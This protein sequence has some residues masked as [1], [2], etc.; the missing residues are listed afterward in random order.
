MR[1]RNISN[2]TNLDNTRG[3]LFFS[4]R[5]EELTFPYT[6]DSYKS[7]TTSL[8]GLAREALSIT[9]DVAGAPNSRQQ[10]AKKSISQIISEIEFR[11]SGNWV[12]KLCVG[13]GFEELSR[14]DPIASSVDHYRRWLEV[15]LSELDG[16]QYIAEIVNQV[17]LRAGS[18]KEKKKLDF[19]A[20]E[21]VSTLQ[22]LGVSR[23]HIHASIIDFFFS[24]TEVS[25]GEAIKEFCKLVFP[26]THKYEV[27]IGVS[28]EI[29]T[30]NRDSLKEMGILRLDDDSE[31]DGLDPDTVK[32]LREELG[33][34]Q[35]AMISVRATD[36]NS[37]VNMAKSKIEQVAAFFMVFNH[38]S[39]FEISEDAVAIQACCG[40]VSKTLKLEGNHMH[41]IRD[42]RMAKASVS[43]KKYH[44][45][46]SLDMGGDHNKFRNVISIHSLSLISSSPDI[47]L[48]NI[49]TCLETI[50]T[51]REGQSNISSVVKAIV[52]AI[53][54]GYINRLVTST[55]FDT[56]NWDRR[57][58]T[59]SLTKADLDG[60][61]DLMSKFVSL[62]TA[63]KNE[64]ALRDLLER[65]KDFE[66]LRFRIYTLAML[67]RDPSK[68][69]SRIETHQKLVTWQ[70][71]RIYRSRNR[72]VH[73]GESPNFTGYLV[74]NAHDFF[75]IALMFCLE[76]SNAKNGYDTFESCF[77]FADGTCRRYLDSLE[78]N[79][80]IDQLWALPRR[81]DRDFIFENEPD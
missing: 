7:P 48:V 6:L 21:F 44:D 29:A 34:R 65:C 8:Q 79:A 76:L 80:P 64:P 70:L 69:K 31:D 12:A 3:L 59:K 61:S 37:A 78:G 17:L 26:H 5:C 16:Q 60:H 50:S 36:Y 68:I 40:G 39:R 1:F 66:L 73:S 67:L 71:H 77:D 43:F 74:E 49:W 72:I 22:G 38:R 30:I 53:T 45:G 62:L 58:F 63:D 2:W 28:D 51:A 57:S 33:A 32:S 9:S 41:F 24:S 81:K 55:V 56:L 10:S 14:L 20:K 52:P 4:Q 25:D 27:A 15:T 47:Q 46:I 13:V 19:L 18:T 42:M 35:V 54:L 23:D 11:L 75:D